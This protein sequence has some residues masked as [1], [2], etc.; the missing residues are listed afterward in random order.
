MEPPEETSEE[1]PEEAS[2]HE[3]TGRLPTGP[4]PTLGPAT[5]MLPRWPGP[6]LITVGL[7]LGLFALGSASLVVR[8]QLDMDRQILLPL[9]IAG[10]ILFGAGLVYSATRQIQMRRVLAPERYRGPSVIVLLAMV[11]LISTVLV[12]PFSADAAALLGGDGEL[13]LLGAIV[14]LVSTSIA[15]LLVS[16]LFVA[17]PKALAALPSF[18][19]RDPQAAVLAG[20]GWG[21]VAWIASTALLVIAAWVL[22]R[23]GMPPEAGTAEL[24]IQRLDPWL[25]VLAVVILAPIAEEI[26]FRGVVFNAWLREGGRIY[27]YIGSAAL[28]AVIHLS[29]VSLVPIFFLGLALAWV[30]ERNG[31]LLAPMAMHATVNGISVALTLLARFDIVRLPV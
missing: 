17:R 18:P 14:I 6:L 5:P 15:L 12:A 11:L 19:G 28:F 24:A 9:A 3:R 26:F 22:E 29:L 30:Y 20:L 7:I 16:W 10:A 21:V 13:S 2:G 4:H 1:T 8:G 31:S 25:I 27:A 23:I